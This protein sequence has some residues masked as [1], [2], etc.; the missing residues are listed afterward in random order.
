MGLKVGLQLY[1]VRQSLQK[2]P[3]RVLAQVAGA[4]YKY[5]EAANHDAANDPGIGFGVPVDKM[6]ASL[7]ELGMSII[8]SH[9]NP[10]RAELI[11]R[12]LDYHEVLGNQ[13]VGCDI[14]FFPY[15]DIDFVLRRCELFN[16]IGKKC[17]D[18]GMRF[19]YHNHYQEFQKFGD[20]T[21]YEII[22]DNTDPSLVFIELDTYW[23]ARGGK[24]P[25]ELIK[26]YKDRV[27]LLH[28]KDF[29][30]DA[31][32]NLVMYDGIINPERL[33]NMDVF[34]A[35]KHPLCF[36]EIGTGVLPI[37][38]IIDTA[39]EAPYLEYIILEQDHTQLDEIESIKV[40]MEAFR[41][42]SGVEWV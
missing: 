20:K 15:G 29:P 22:M 41:K 8:G 30:K 9:I 3:Y 1:S 39:K 13:Q 11:D 16:H 4:G 28:Q 25:V 26:K 19:Y 6:K 35:T 21:V 18:R 31:P 36:T 34:L 24:N 27:V 23:A 32:Q 38:D 2:D 12:I 42:F 14:E 33:I 7:E 37:Q 10:L 5:L 17:K 40:S